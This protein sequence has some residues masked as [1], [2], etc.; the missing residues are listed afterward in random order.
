MCFRF[1][2]CQS[3]RFHGQTEAN[4][5]PD[6]PQNPQ[7]ILPKPLHRIPNG[8]ENAVFQIVSAAKGVGKAAM[9]GPGHGIDSEIPPGKIRLHMGDKGYPVRMTIV[10]VGSLCAEGG[11]FHHGAVGDDAYSAVFFAC[12]NQGILGKY[13]FRL[14]RQSGSAK[15]K[16]R[17]LQSQTV[18][19]YAAADAPGLVSGIFQSG[20]TFRNIRRQN[21]SRYALSSVSGTGVMRHRPVPLQRT[22][23]RYS[24]K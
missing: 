5:K 6:T 4:R 8:P 21:H 16:I 2:G 20:N 23:P 1:H 15:V 12:K 3:G 11:D 7:G 9:G 19:P 18:I 13:R 17:R 10:P 24:Q 14:L 22:P